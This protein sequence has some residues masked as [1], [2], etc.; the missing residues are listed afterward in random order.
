MVKKIKVLQIGKKNWSEILPLNSF[1][2]LVWNYINLND[3][4]TLDLEILIG[5]QKKSTFDAVICTDIWN[6][7]I[8][9]ELFP[10]IECYS[11]VIDSKLKTE[12]SQTVSDMKYPIYM[13]FQNPKS[14]VHEIYNNFFSGQNGSKLHVNQIVVSKT[15]KGR[16]SILGES[17]IELDGDFSESSVDPYL[18]W[19]YNIGLNKKDK[20]IWLEFEKEGTV[21]IE[22][23]I[24]SIIEGT[25]EIS[26]VLT[27]S[28]EAINNGIEI[29]YQDNIGYLSVSL[30]IHGKGKLKIGP[31]HYRDSRHQFGEFILGG[32]KI[33]DSKNQE[34]FYYFN[35]GDL[36]PPLNVYFSGYRSAEGFEGFY[37]MK[38]LGSPFLLITDPRLE[39]G[40]FYMGSKELED[41]LVQIIENTLDKLGFSHQELILSGLSMGTFGALYYST[42]F[43]PYSVIIGKPLTNIGEVAKKEK[44]VRPGGFPTSLDILYSLTGTLKKEGIE[45]LNR[46][47]WDKFDKGKYSN[48]QFIVAYMKDDDYDNQAYPQLVQHLASKDSSIISKGITGRHN[49]NSQAINEW[50]IAQYKRVLR[51]KFLKEF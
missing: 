2:E 32:K 31:L 21:T 35:P 8:I 51:D 24:L 29:P 4:S 36:K 6:E 13:N 5:N 49:D 26:K 25:S 1:E 30:S 17:Y 7:R 42:N 18:T 50:F 11:M 48:T 46:R 22:M 3:T 15:F 45:C 20:K 9:R 33:S 12:V 41:K 34:I 27:Y 38:N 43:E 10:V 16:K 47:F 44:L 37:M 40:A 14:V 23:K 28:E 39:G 19:Q